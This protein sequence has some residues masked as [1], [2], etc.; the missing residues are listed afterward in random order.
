MHKKLFIPGPTEVAPDVLQKMA[1]PMIGHRSKDASKLQTGN[2]RQD[3]QGVLHAEPDPPLHQLGSG[4]MEGSIRSLTAK[5][6]IV[7]SVGAF[8]NRWF[9]M[10][11]ANNVPADKLESE[12]GKPTTPRNGGQVPRH[13]QVRRLHRHAQ[14][15]QH[16]H[17]E[18]GRGDRRGPEE[19]PRRPLARR[20]GQLDGRRED[21]SGQ[22]RHRRLHHLDA[23]GARPSSRAWRS[24][25]S[26]RAR[27]NTASR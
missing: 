3:A 23:E 10:A 12:W 20:Y 2:Q 16:R 8:G 9:K 19:I 22:A 15:D 21:R 17:H 27:S 26:S 6:A 24:A 1:T 7:F 18:P 13:R 14:R 11:E 25:P 4:L 5:R